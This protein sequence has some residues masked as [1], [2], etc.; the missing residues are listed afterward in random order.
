MHSVPVAPRSLALDSLSAYR[1]LRLRGRRLA[2]RRCGDA[3]GEPVVLLHALASHSGTWSTIA[4]ALAGQGFHVIAPDLRGHGRSDWTASYA[5]ADFEDDLGALLDAL[6]LGAINLIGHSL[7]GHLALKFATRQPERVRRLVIEA[8]PVPPRDVADA[9]ALAASRHGHWAASLRRLGIGR[10]L[11][12][13]LSR[14][15]DVRAA[16]SVLPELRAPMP[17]WWARLATLRA[18]CLLLA[19]GDDGAISVRQSLL[20]ARIPH[21]VARQIGAGHR[22]HREHEAAFLADVLAFIGPPAQD[23]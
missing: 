12:L 21:A 18:P 22:L 8:A 6:E 2:F 20:A 23:E 16:R 13:M 11:W 17:A 9:A 19:S 5:L 3:G 4:P 7:G 15:F 14:Q 10:L 1:F